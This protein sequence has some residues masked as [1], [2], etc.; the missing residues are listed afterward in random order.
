MPIGR[1]TPGRLKPRDGA[2]VCVLRAYSIPP[3]PRPTEYT[4]HTAV[5]PISNKKR[6][7]DSRDD[8][9]HSKARF[10]RATDMLDAYCRCGYQ[11]LI[12]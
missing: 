8:D 11:H 7:A 3:W 1:K 2:V 4:M 10:Y 5:C 12:G 9:K 6:S